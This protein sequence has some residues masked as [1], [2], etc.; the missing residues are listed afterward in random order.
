MQSRTELL[1]T[2]PRGYGIPASN[3]Q[4]ACCRILDGVP[5]GDLWADPDVDVCADTGSRLRVGPSNS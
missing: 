1:F 4:R 3:C 2:D 5:L